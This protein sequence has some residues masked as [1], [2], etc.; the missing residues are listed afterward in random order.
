VIV[1]DLSAAQLR[2]ALTGDGLRMQIGPF[3]VRLRSTFSSVRDYIA[4]HYAFFPVVESPGLHFTAEVRRTGFWR[5]LVRPQAT[6][7]ADSRFPFTPLP[8]RLAPGLLEWGLN[9]CVGR[10]PHPWLLLH[11]AVIERGGRAA[12]L[13]APPG[14]GKSTL[15]AALAFSGW[16]LLSDEFAIVDP[17]SGDVVPI[18]RPIA[19]KRQS[20]DVMR[21]RV[22]DINLGPELEDNE[23][24][25]ARYV[26]PPSSAVERLHERARPA[27]VVVP[28]WQAGSATI[29]E[30]DSRARTLFHLADSSFN[31]NTHG[32][33]G[34]TLLADL[35]DEA[36]CYKLTYSNLDEA[37]AVFDRLARGEVIH[38]E[39]ANAS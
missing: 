31:L 34:F 24:N 10:L 30:P 8:A 19:L 14:S 35:V 27:W 33:A 1:R 39:G 12:L 21:A 25:P 22:P 7:G 38:P 18:P 23:G 28:K 3:V 16:R 2:T 13:P 5:T 37:L 11:S 29:L 20:I 4:S 6:F 26:A 32:K 36:S 9:W 17:Q 15:C